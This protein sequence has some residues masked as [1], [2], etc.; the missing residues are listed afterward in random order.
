[1]VSSIVMTVKLFFK[2]YL[3]V[4]IPYPLTNTLY[5][6]HNIEM[7]GGK[8]VSTVTFHKVLMS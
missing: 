5:Y 7:N 6:A 2:L 1:M 4:S 8:N 3:K